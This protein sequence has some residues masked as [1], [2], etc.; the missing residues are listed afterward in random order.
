M[1]Q[2]LDAYIKLNKL[3][4]EMNQP[5]RILTEMSHKGEI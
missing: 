4:L 5:V 1:F 3:L 2:Y